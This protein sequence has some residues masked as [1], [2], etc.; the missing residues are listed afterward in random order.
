MNFFDLN[1]SGPFIDL[2][3]RY[4]RSP[5]PL[6]QLHYVSQRRPE[7]TD[8]TMTN[9][10]ISAGVRNFLAG[11][12]GRLW[13]SPRH[14]VQLLEGSASAV[15]AVF[16]RISADSRHTQVTCFSR[17][18]VDERAIVRPMSYSRIGS[19]AWSEVG[20]D[21]AAPELPFDTA[22]EALIRRGPLTQGK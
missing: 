22:C 2:A 17:A 16:R 21:A 15:E 5:T 18:R 20:N 7:M 11:I 14:F 19:H 9:V 8:D 6:V 4:A 1:S 3:A 13:V 12:S 10:L